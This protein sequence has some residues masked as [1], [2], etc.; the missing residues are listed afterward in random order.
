M[1][2]RHPYEKGV[3]ACQRGMRTRDNP[4][5]ARQTA[6]QIE[7]FRDWLQ[8]F[9]DEARREADDATKVA[10]RLELV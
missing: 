8:G 6:R 3:S 1:R 4:Y 7:Q 2:A 10:R 5:K 9:A